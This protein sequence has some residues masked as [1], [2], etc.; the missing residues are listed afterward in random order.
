MQLSTPNDNSA[1]IQIR[2]GEVAPQRL[3]IPS[4]HCPL[5]TTL[6][7]SARHNTPALLEHMAA[8]APSIEI[9]QTDCRSD[10]VLAALAA[11]KGLRYS[12]L[13]NCKII[14]P[15]AFDRW[16]RL[17]TLVMYRNRGQELLDVRHQGLR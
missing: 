9:L 10:S 8:H 14:P 3:Q 11:F 5:L 13:H 6:R 17:D 1:A 15:H 16:P 4:L 7:L 12:R 2:G